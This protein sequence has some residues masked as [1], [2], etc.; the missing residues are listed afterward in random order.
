MDAKQAVAVAKVYFLELVGVEP[1][2]EE[3]WFEQSSKT[4]CITFG[5][6]RMLLDGTGG[7]VTP[8]VRREIIEYKIVRVSDEDGKAISLLNRETGRAA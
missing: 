8:S 3:V 2:V 7:L 6:S 1:S 5:R 4:W